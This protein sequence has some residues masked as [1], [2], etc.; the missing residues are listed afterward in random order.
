MTK[1]EVFEQFK[2]E[3]I[4]TDSVT[5]QTTVDGK[6]VGRQ[7]W[8]GRVQKH[9]IKDE[10]VV[11]RAANAEEFQERVDEMMCAEAKQKGFEP[12]MLNVDFSMPKAEFDVKR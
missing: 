10:D 6:I 11:I 12:G 5:G 9:F 1:E 4:Q 3:L 7:L 8:I 2:R